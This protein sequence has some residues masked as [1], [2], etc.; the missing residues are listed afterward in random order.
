MLRVVAR[1]AAHW[2]LALLFALPVAPVV[3]LAQTGPPLTFAET[4]AVVQA[5]VDAYNRHDINGVLATVAPQPAY[6]YGDCDYV[7]HDTYG[8]K[9]KAA[10]VQMLRDRFA[11]NDH[12]QVNTIEEAGLNH[13]LS[14]YTFS[15]SGTRTNDPIT[16]Q[17][18]PPQYYGPKGGIDRSTH[19]IDAVIAADQTACQGHDFPR[20][21]PSALRTRTIT[22]DFLDAYAAHDTGRILQLLSSRVSYTDYSYAR[23]QPV[24]LAGKPALK[25]WLRRRFAESDR[26][27]SAMV[28]LPSP[29]NLDL[30]VVRTTR[31]SRSISAR[32]LVPQATRIR[33]VLQR[34]NENFTGYF[35]L[36]ARAD[37]TPAAG[38]A[39]CT[40]R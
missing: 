32:Q 11:E 39:S 5:F 34:R 18:L 16:V 19:L 31:T 10:F 27:D 35:Y 6:W 2:P 12:L 7:W 17:G 29:T 13:Q 9:G 24:T 36:V 14:P 38:P 25:R 23:C 33:L 1:A 30:A 26:F 21:E 20:N 3:T 8:I 37:V 4:R 22:Q 40:S 28:S 15:L